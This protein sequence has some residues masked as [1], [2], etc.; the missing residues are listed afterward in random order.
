MSRYVCLCTVDDAKLDLFR[1]LR[2]SHYAY[3]LG[4]QDRIVF[5]GPARVAEG[6]APETMI[7]VVEAASLSEA[8]TFIAAEPYTAHGAFAQV[9]VR[10]WSQ[11][12]PEETPG[13]LR[14]TYGALIQQTEA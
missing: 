11:V 4:A 8:E 3:L 6:G 13:G 9:V 10:P 5:G 14:E 7:I 2:A 12:L 1:D